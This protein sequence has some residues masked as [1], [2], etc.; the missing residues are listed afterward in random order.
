[1]VILPVMD[2][3]C[4]V[5]SNADTAAMTP[6]GL[7]CKSSNRSCLHRSL[8]SSLESSVFQ[9]S[10]NAL[11]DG[12]RP[13]LVRVIRKKSEC[14]AGGR[15]GFVFFCSQHTCLIREEITG[16]CGCRRGNDGVGLGV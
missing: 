8:V 10:V 16:A 11:L 3:S 12:G 7:R 9:R 14:G 4:V 2:G 15:G 5:W 1:M 6:N 13:D